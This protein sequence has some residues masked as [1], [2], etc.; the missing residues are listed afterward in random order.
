M[1]A[2]RTDPRE[3]GVSML[4]EA[5]VEYRALERRALAQSIEHRQEATGCIGG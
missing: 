1:K 2:K 5:Y 3:I 4:V